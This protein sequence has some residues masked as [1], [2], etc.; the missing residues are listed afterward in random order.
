MKQFNDSAFS[1][2]VTE[3]EEIDCQNDSDSDDEMSLDDISIILPNIFNNLF[4][5][6][7]NE[8]KANKKIWDY[9]IT[10][11]PEILNYKETSLGLGVLACAMLTCPTSLECEDSLQMID[12][13]H[14][15]YVKTL[16][17]EK[18][19]DNNEL[20][21][22]S[23]LWPYHAFSSIYIWNDFI[24]RKEDKITISEKRLAVVD[25]AQ[26][27]MTKPLLIFNNFFYL[28]RYVE[29]NIDSLTTFAA[30]LEKPSYTD[31]THVTPI[32][33]VKTTN[34]ILFIVL[35]SVGEFI[36][37]LDIKIKKFKAQI[38]F[39]QFEMQTSNK[40]CFD[41]AIRLLLSINQDE[42]NFI[43]FALENNVNINTVC[44]NQEQQEIIKEIKD[45]CIIN[46]EEIYDRIIMALTQANRF[47]VSAK[48]MEEMNRAKLVHNICF[49][50][51]LPPLMLMYTENYK[52]IRMHKQLG[53]YADMIKTIENTPEIAKYIEFRSS[54]PNLGF[55]DNTLAKDYSLYRYEALEYQR[56]VPTI[57]L[58][59]LERID[60]IRKLLPCS[61]LANNKLA[62]RL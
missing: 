62:P 10:Y 3:L 61:L 43:Q 19:L 13:L 46:Q 36:P 33:V 32:Y 44:E 23:L 59:D 38:I 53:E 51:K 56:S 39:N 5:S 55:F 29:N 22:Y 21:I 49:L 45:D 42:E 26:K 54:T 15:Y 50:T 34:T 14:D 4:L 24:G 8:G 18:V 9:A 60:N 57:T 27:Y 7:Y 35:D 48:Y 17:S 11:Y 52:T 47:K 28:K 1:T 2:P 58:S 41:G 20:D 25:E 16:N 40:G 6:Y 37:L 31:T 12:L 30:I